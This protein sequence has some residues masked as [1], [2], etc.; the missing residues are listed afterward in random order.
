MAGATPYRCTVTV[1]GTKFDAI[2]T[3]F[4]LGSRTD[5]NNLPKMGSLQ[6][7]MWVYADF[8]DSNNV[9]FS[10]IQSLF[11][12][13]NVVTK[14]KIKQMKVEFWKDDKK[15]DAL[16]SISFNGWISYFETSNME[17]NTLDKTY[18]DSPEQDIYTSGVP[19]LLNH[20]LAMEL[21]PALNQQNFSN[22]K[23]GN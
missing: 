18:L 22:L 5:N 1:D 2:S 14:D 6:A 23:I 9:P 3:N 10:T 11:Q 15:Q 16:A 13:A 20:M 17:M 12:L 21:T 7:S 8:H 4:T 19:Q